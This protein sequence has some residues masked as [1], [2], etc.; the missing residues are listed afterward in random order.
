MKKLLL[1]AIFILL[2]VLC[3]VPALRAQEAIGNMPRPEALAPEETPTHVEAGA[4]GEKSTIDEPNDTDPA[5]ELRAIRESLQLLRER[6]ADMGADMTNLADQVRK[7]RGELEEVGNPERLKSDRQDIQ[8]SMEDLAARIRKIE[9]LSGT[10]KSMAKDVKRDATTQAAVPDTTQEGKPDLKEPYL[11]AFGDFK[12]G[13]YDKAR[14]K[15]QAFLKQFPNASLASGAQFWIGE[16]YYLEGNFAKAILE[17]DK[18]LLNYPKGEMVPLALLKQGLSFLKIGDKTGARIVLEKLSVD[19]PD[20]HQAQ[21]AKS[22][23]A[24]LK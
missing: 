17:Y 18:A 7:L 3:L 22:T 1:S 9:N 23:L 14:R 21:L 6:Q 12:N 13:H 24:N 15:F 5:E 4:G 8:T 16:C 11:E 10:G 19:Y 20:T 2:F